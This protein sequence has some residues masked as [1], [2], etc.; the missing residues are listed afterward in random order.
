MVCNKWDNN[1]TWFYLALNICNEM[2][3]GGQSLILLLHFGIQTFTTSTE[4][5]VLF[6]F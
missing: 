4:E 2:E 3:H 6:R 5:S 1:G